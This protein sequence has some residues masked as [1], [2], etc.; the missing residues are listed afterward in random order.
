MPFKS[1]QGCLPA[2]AEVLK[3]NRTTLYERQRALVREGLL[4]ALP[5]HGR[6]S[7]VRATSESVAMLTIGMLASVSLADVG[8]LARSFGEAGSIASKCPLTGAK[9]FHAALSRIF[10]DETLAERVS[11][12]SVQVNAGRAAIGFDGSDA[13]RDMNF[14]SLK[15]A[16]E[17][18][19]AKNVKVSPDPTS[20]IFSTQKHEE[21]GLRVGVSIPRQTVR[22]L[23]AVART[24]LTKETE[25]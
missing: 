19:G 1:L 7:G 6:G 17:R 25:Q 8:P 18:R 22:D 20:S 5:G 3:V 11:G 4:D 24:L 12:I 16:L 21:R 13:E 14:V 10:S 23:T 15:S 2:L 9:T